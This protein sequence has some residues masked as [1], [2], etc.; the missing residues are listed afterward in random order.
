MKRRAL[1]AAAVREIIPKNSSGASRSREHGGS[2]A[3]HSAGM[4]ILIKPLLP[5]EIRAIPKF[6]RFHLFPHPAVTW[7]SL[8]PLEESQRAAFVEERA[9][10]ARGMHPPTLLSSRANCKLEYLLRDIGTSTAANRRRQT[11]PLD[12]DAI[13]CTALNRIVAAM[14]KMRVG[15]QH[16]PRARRAAFITR[17]FST[18][19]ADCDQVVSRFRLYRFYRA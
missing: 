8:L 6:R 17:A 12:L 1:R 4:K 11:P 14:W 5:R 13:L 16:V 10:G 7:P 2:F 19:R 18:E 3:S 15:I 9:G